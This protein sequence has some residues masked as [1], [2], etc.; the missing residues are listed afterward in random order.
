MVSL[1]DSQFGFVSGRGTTNAIFVVQKL[2]EKNLAVNKQLYMTFVVLEKTF[3]HVPQ[4]VIWL[5]LRKLG[6]S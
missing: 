2:Q 4:N 5:G 1:D 3:D 6:G